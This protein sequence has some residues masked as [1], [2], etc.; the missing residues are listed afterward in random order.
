MGVLK[1]KQQ[2]LENSPFPIRH[3]CALSMQDFS[4]SSK[5]GSLQVWVFLLYQRTWGK[6]GKGNYSAS[7]PLLKNEY[8]THLKAYKIIQ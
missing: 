7:I 5:Q 3:Q 6:K 4:L 2:G 8:L 1:G